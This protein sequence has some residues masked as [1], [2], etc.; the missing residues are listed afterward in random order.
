MRRIALGVAVAA[1][2]SVGV[3]GVRAQDKP[4]RIA[5]VEFIKAKP[6]MEAQLE[7]AGKKHLGWHRKQGDTWTIHLWQVITGDNAGSYYLGTFGHSWKD[8][9]ARE[10]FDAAD[11]QDAMAVVG[12]YLLSDT[13]SLWRVVEDASRPDPMAKGPTKFVQ[14]THYF[15]KPAKLSAFTDAIKEIKT[16]LDGAEFPVHT[17]WYA[18]ASGGQGPHFIAATDRGSWAEFAGPEKSMS[19]VLDEKLG[20]RRATELIDAIRDAIT[21]TYSEALLYRPDLSYLPSK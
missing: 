4:D 20:A 13:P 15:V 21:S 16:T 12:P 8:F 17:D 3:P 7:A 5:R 6:G 18:L 1:V 10:A 9:D 14:L 11:E 19:K 2:L